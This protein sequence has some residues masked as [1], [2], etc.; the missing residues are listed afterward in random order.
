M[1]S[2]TQRLENKQRNYKGG[3]YGEIDTTSRG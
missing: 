1:L 3:R 2:L